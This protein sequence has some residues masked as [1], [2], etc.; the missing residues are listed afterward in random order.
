MMPDMNYNPQ[1][2]GYNQAFFNPYGYGGNSGVPSFSQMPT[3]GGYPSMGMPSISNMQMGGGYPS[4]DMG[5]APGGFMNN[6]QA[7]LQD[8]FSKYFN[9]GQVAIDPAAGGPAPTAGNNANTSTTLGASAT[10]PTTPDFGN[11]GG[12]LDKGKGIT[13]KAEKKLNNMGYND[14]QLIQARQ[15]GGGAQGFRGALGGM[16][17]MSS[18]QTSQGNYRR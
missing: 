10:A 14:E 4:M 5:M 18:N 16:T 8:M 3:A 2:G 15:A 6:F 13:R 7:Q 1:F 12:R 11:L 17:P 9:Q